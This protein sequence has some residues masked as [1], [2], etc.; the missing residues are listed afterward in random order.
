MK[1]ERVE[2]YA[3]RMV[4]PHVQDFL[5]QLHRQF[6]CGLLWTRTTSE[7]FSS[8]Q[9]ITAAPL[10]EESWLHYLT[11]SAGG[12][13]LLG[14]YA[15]HIASSTPGPRQFGKPGKIGSIRLETSVHATIDIPRGTPKYLSEDGSLPGFLCWAERFRLH[16]GSVCYRL[17]TSAGLLWL[18]PFSETSL[19]TLFYEQDLPVQGKPTVVHVA[20]TSCYMTRLLQYA[21]GPWTGFESRDESGRVWKVGP[22]DLEFSAGCRLNVMGGYNDRLRTRPITVLQ[23]PYDAIWQPDGRLGFGLPLR[24]TAINQ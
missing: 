17:E 18:R 22:S 20:Q 13:A 21:H 15:W 11:P 1:I 7:W 8:T 4:L 19:V 10:G 2:D 23:P 6:T 16:D 5:H 24:L 3:K 12:E 14:E 9:T